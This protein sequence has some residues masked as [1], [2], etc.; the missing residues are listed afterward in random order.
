MAGEVVFG[1]PGRVEAQFFSPNDLFQGLF[2]IPG[3]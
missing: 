1:Q 3:F 2:V